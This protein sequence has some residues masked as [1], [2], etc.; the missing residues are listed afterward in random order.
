MKVQLRMIDAQVAEKHR[1]RAEK[2]RARKSRVRSSWPSARQ[3]HHGEGRQDGR[4]PYSEYDFVMWDGE[5]PK[6]T[7]YSLFGSSLGDEICK[8]HLTTE[9]CFNLLLTSKSANP[10]TIFV[11]FG[12]RYDFDEICRQS[13]PLDRLVRL[14]ETGHVTWHGY[15]I[16]QAEGKFFTLKK[17][18]TTVTIYEIFGWFHKS[19][20]KALTDFRIGTETERA[21]IA[22]DKERRAV[23]LWE[24][25]EHIRKYW[26]LELKLGPPL[27]DC[28]RDIC[29]AAGFNPKAWYG[30]SALAL[31]ALRRNNITQYMGH[32]PEVVKRASQ[33]AYAGGR[34]EGVRGGV[35]G[36]VYSKD[37]N[38]AYMSAAL[39]LPDLAHGHWRRGKR[40]EP[41]KFAI[42]HIKYNGIRAAERKMEDGQTYHDPAY[43][44]P[45]FCRHK[46][47]MVDWPARVEGWY[48]APEAELVK[49]SPYATFIEAYIFEESNPRCRPFEFVADWFDKR[50]LLESLP[51]SNPSR[52]AGKAFKWALAAIYGQLARTVGW[53]RFRRT[54]PKY[55]QLEWAGYITSKCRAEMW[56]L[57]QQAGDK[58]ISIDTD[59]VTAMCDLTVDEG[60]ALGQW[61]TSYADVG[62]FFQSGVYALKC[63]GEW[64][65]RKARGVEEDART[66]RLPISPEMIEAAIRDRQSIVLKPRVRYVSIRMALNHQLGAMGDWREHPGDELVFGGNGKRIHREGS[67]WYHKDGRITVCESAEV[68]VFSP[69]PAITYKDYSPG[70]C[71]MSQP[72]LLPWKDNMDG[73]PDRNLIAD[74]LWVDPDSIDSDDYWIKELLTA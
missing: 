21:A 10:E 48:W 35:L 16:K 19:Y 26:R 23:F 34:F 6:D 7:G 37:K 42:Y 55:H 36:P 74:I 2:E 24:S 38:S 14:K 56:K 20:V 70:G 62:V 39:D 25:I 47:G 41:G 43:V 27:M 59:S 61:K 28:I 45:L 68:H 52:Q 71:P 11:I 13:M 60:K 49:D 5:A 66:R 1:V 9:D 22:A 50:V 15:T 30:P 63:D 33:Y 57:A 73:V 44:H 53:D 17:D 65:E 51:K 8:P 29:I 3:P 69:R 12:G 54:A 46:N 31:E 58:L 4:K 40:Y 64:V 32:V 18:G 72:H 67:C